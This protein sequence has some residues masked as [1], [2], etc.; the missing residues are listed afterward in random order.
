VEC[1]LIGGSVGVIAFPFDIR[2]GL[3]GDYLLQW[4]GTVQSTGE[5]KVASLFLKLFRLEEPQLTQDN[6][7][8]P[9]PHLQVYEPGK[10]MT[11]IRR[12]AASYSIEKPPVLHTPSFNKSQPTISDTTNRPNPPKVGVNQKSIYH[13]QRLPHLFQAMHLLKAPIEILMAVRVMK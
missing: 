13:P 12:V 1:Q 4:M 7:H 10:H 9:P 6:F 11:D 8:I 5:G 2:M 3:R